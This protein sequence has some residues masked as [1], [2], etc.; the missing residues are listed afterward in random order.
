MLVVLTVL[1]WRLGLGMAVFLAVAV[2]VVVRG[3]H[4]AVRESSDE[5]GAYARLYGG[6]EERLTAAE[7]LRANGAGVHA[8]WRF[9]EDSR[10]RAA[11]LGAPG[12]GV[13]PHVVDGAGRDHRRL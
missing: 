8:M 7:D 9:V 12:A 10:R 5:L 2:T 3:R 6:I 13:H 4:R 11:Q 1:D